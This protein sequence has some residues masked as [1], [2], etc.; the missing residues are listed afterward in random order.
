MYTPTHKNLVNSDTK[1]H[2]CKQ[3][4]TTQPHIIRVCVCITTPPV[5]FASYARHLCVAK[6][7]AKLLHEPALDAIQQMICVRTPLPLKIA[8]RHTYANVRRDTT[9]THDARWQR[10]TFTHSRAPPQRCQRCVAFLCVCGGEWGFRLVKTIISARDCSLIPSHANAPC[11]TSH[12]H[13]S[14]VFVCICCICVYI[15]YT[16]YDLAV[17]IFKVNRLIDY[18]ICYI[19]TDTLSHTYTKAHTHKQ[20]EDYLHT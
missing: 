19:P 16:F 9:D 20:P 18:R 15:I 17:R 1:A 3:H 7:F 13:A 11:P 2:S 12:A 4:H 8:G 5:V 10:D 6:L 14:V